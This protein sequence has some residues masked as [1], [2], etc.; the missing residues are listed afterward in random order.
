M[1]HKHKMYLEQDA[2]A[3]DGKIMPQQLSLNSFSEFFASVPTELRELSPRRHVLQLL[4]W[5]F[6]FI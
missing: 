3:M 4:V 2:D 6:Y 5:G 1:K